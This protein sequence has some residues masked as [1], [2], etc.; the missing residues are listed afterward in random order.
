MEGATIITHILWSGAAT[1]S[2][3]ITIVTSADLV[4][5]S[6]PLIYM[7]PAAPRLQKR[8]YMGCY[9]CSVKCGGPEKEYYGKLGGF[10]HC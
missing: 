9:S 8:C 10:H 5:E 6:F 2:R 1:V 4:Q 3:F 7:C